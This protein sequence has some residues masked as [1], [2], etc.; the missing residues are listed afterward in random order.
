M[1]INPSIVTVFFSLAL[2]FWIACTPGG[3]E[4]EEQRVLNQKRIEMEGQLRDIET[5][6]KAQ[7]IDEGS[8]LTLVHDRE[9]L[10]S[11]LE[12]LKERLAGKH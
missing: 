5:K 2:G 11:R 3:R 6:L 9:L 8:R 12:R 1:K 10:R 4:G 7:G